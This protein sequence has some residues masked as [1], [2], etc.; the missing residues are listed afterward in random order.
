MNI[1][2]N[3]I[4]CGG[5]VNESQQITDAYFAAV[6]ADGGV[7]GNKGISGRVIGFL[8]NQQ[9]ADNYAAFLTYSNLVKADGGVIGNSQ[10]TQTVF[11]SL[12]NL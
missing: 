12:I 7:I 2:A 5:F 10:I 8:Y 6:A 3:I 1:L 11:N 4:G 9:I